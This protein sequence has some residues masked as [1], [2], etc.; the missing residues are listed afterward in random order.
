MIELNKICKYFE[1]SSIRKEILNNVSIRIEQNEI[2]GLIGQN[3]SGK[4]TLLKI[5]SGLLMPSSGNINFENYSS[6]LSLITPNNRSFYWRLT[7]KENLEFFSKLNSLTKENYESEIYHLSNYFDVSKKLDTKFMHLSEGEM[8]KAS[9]IRG[10]IFKPKIVLF[11]E[12]TSYLDQKSSKLLVDYVKNY[13][14]NGRIAIWCSHDLDKVENLSSKIGVVSGNNVHMFESK[15]E[16][17][18]YTYNLET[19]DKKILAKLDSE[20]LDYDYYVDNDKFF[21]NFLPPE[22]KLNDICSFL[23]MNLSSYTMSKNKGELR[24]FYNKLLKR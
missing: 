22:E 21:I 9:I 20:D 19:D 24:F 17:N 16:K 8:Q 14:C 18:A 11:D 6:S 23:D 15:Q 7:L 5:I 13:I 4:S 10:L 3:G 12:P 1:Y 2:F